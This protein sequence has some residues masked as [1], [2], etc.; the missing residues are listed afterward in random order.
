MNKGAIAYLLILLAVIIIIYI[1][2]GFRFLSAK[3][4]TTIPAKTTTSSIQNVTLSTSTIQSTALCSNFQITGSA[5]NTTYVDNC[6]YNG[7]MLGLWVAAGYGGRESVQIVGADGKT[8]VNESSMY[9]CTAFYQNFTAP[10]QLYTVIFKTGAGGGSC[11]SPMLIINTTTTPPVK[12]YEYIYNGNFGNGQYTGWNVTSPGFGTAPLNISYADSKLC[13]QGR[14]WSNYNGSYLATTYNCGISTS[15]G[16]MTSSPFIVDPASPFL[17]FRLISP[18]DNNLYLEILRVNYKI[19]ND[20]QV[21]TNSTPVAIVHFNTYNLSVTANSSSTFA[22]ATI[23]L[24]LFTNEVVQVR[25][26]AKEVGSNFIAAGDF[27]LAD[28]PHQDLYVTSNF[29]SISG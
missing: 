5:L 21:Y 28:R 8:Y 2:T 15:P 11:G 25:I 24:T 18:Q 20:Q 12:A 16:N 3:K 14:P 10:A 7:G 27:V 1:F 17:N 23:P 22:N 13:Y 19:I 9:N 26:V 4:T 29:T 6:T